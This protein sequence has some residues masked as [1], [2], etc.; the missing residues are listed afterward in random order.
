MKQVQLMIREEEGH[1]QTKFEICREIVQ[2]YEISNN[3][4]VLR[5]WEMHPGQF[6]FPHM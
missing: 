3:C 5:K 2:Q 4:Y 1:L 6:S